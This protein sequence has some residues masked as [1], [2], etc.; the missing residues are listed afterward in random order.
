MDGDIA[1]LRKIAALKKKYANM[2]LIVDEAHGFGTFGER[3]LGVLE[4]LDLL[5]EVDIII[6]TLGKAAASAGA[7]A[8][9]DG[10]MRDFLVN[11]SRSFIFSTAMP[12]V[13][14]AWSLLMIEKLTAMRREREHLQSLGK[15]L[16]EKVEVITGQENP[17][18]SQIVPVMAGSAERSITLASAL[19][20]GDYDCL[21]IRRPTVPPGTERLRISLNALLTEETVKGLAE[22]LRKE[23]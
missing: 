22:I 12:P 17:S 5:Y 13:Q 9:A 7:F 14:Q 16:R 18:M 11:T 15:L 20:E 2:L 3:G 10:D 21:P 23:Y 8:I 4:E 19:R 6:G 1:P